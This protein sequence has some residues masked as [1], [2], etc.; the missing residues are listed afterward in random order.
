MNLDNEIDG[1]IVQLPLPKH[2]MN[3]KFYYLLIQVKMLMVFTL[4]ILEKWLWFKSFIPAT[5]YGIMKLIEKYDIQTEGK[6]VLL[7]EEVI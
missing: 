6:I 7:L 1:F 3:K 2:I 5:P 4:Q